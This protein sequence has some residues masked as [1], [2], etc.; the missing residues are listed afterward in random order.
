[1]PAALPLL[2]ALVVALALL[3]LTQS[4]RLS[5]AITWTIVGTW[6]VITTEVLSFLE[7]VAYVPVLLVW[8][9]PT[10]GLLVFRRTDIRAGLAATRSRLAT[11]TGGW[12]LAASLT[13]AALGAATLAA[14]TLYPVTNWDSLTY[15]LPRVVMWMQNQSV[16][17]F[18]TAEPR[19]LFSS[20][21]AEYVILH[22]KVLAAGGG[23]TGIW[24]DWLAG[25]VQW[26]AYG[27]S[28]ST[29]SLIAKS[30]GAQQRGQW[31]AALAAASVP[32]AVLQASTTQVDLTAAAW[33]LVATLLLVQAVEHQENVSWLY[34]GLSGLAVGLAALSKAT[35]YMVLAPL[36]AIA[37]V[38]A[39]RLARKH[40]TFREL[41]WAVCAG[42]LCFVLAVS[43]VYARN[44]GA[45]DGDFLA[46]TAPTNASTIN[47][48]ISP[49]GLAANTVL[50]L[51]ML[52]ATPFSWVN[53]LIESLVRQLLNVVGMG[54]QLG[55]VDATAWGPYQLPR[56]ANS[57]DY[58]G[59]PLTA[60]TLLAGILL[61]RRSALAKGPAATYALATTVSLLLVACLVLWQP[62]VNRLLLGNLLLFMPLVGLAADNQVHTHLTAERRRTWVFASLLAL[63]ALFALALT[64]IHASRPLTSFAPPGSERI[65][66]PSIWNTPYVEREMNEV[67]AESSAA[68]RAVSLAISTSGIDSLCID[69]RAGDFYV[70]P[71]MSANPSV[72]YSYIQDAAG[73]RG[74]IGEP[75]A[76]AATVSILPRETAGDAAQL[77]A[78][79]GIP[80]TSVIT[81]PHRTSGG[82]LLLYWNE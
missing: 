28:V 34:A 36:I 23:F 46:L 4:L 77:S 81:G 25:L 59:A 29:V 17:L 66:L 13:L 2:T 14:A 56:S 58:A 44:A 55:A 72:R 60:L 41:I 54:P 64:A 37:L 47:P 5:I 19:M 33:C 35:S 39:A 38:R 65:A 7:A 12:Q 27:V 82:V 30:L 49:P 71:I 69:Q 32:M 61:T 6:T 21:F 3:G 18:P 80:A 24:S 8:L 62:W 79:L 52:A 1:M 53:D 10:A 74:Q 16:D 11:L 76:C 20:V 67:G 40:Q 50:N 75:L 57:A 15:H 78:D 45:L 31:A 63:S 26:V 42:I 73:I 51:S 70:Y 22:L 48:D 9:L 68:L 43:P